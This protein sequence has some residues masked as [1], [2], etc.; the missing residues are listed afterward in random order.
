[1][2]KEVPQPNIDTAGQPQSLRDFWTQPAGPIPYP[3][4]SNPLEI[5]RT[6]PR[7]VTTPSLW[8]SV[9]STPRTQPYSELEKT[10]APS[11][12]VLRERLR[13]RGVVTLSNPEL[14]SL[15]LMTEQ[16]SESIM[17]RVNILLTEY[18]LQQLLNV[19]LGELSQQYGLGEAKA[20]QL[21]AMLE[22]SR[23]WTLQPEGERRTIRTAADAANLVRAEMEHL[24]HEE[25]RVL[26]L[27]TKNGVVANQRLYQGTVN[28]SVLR[29]AELFRLAV[30]RNCPGII[31]CHN[32]PSG[33]PEA[34]DADIEVTKGLVE[35][36][37]IL[38]VDLVDHII[39]GSNGR[40]TSLKEKMRW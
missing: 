7:N 9:S 29:S 33:S 28:S 3:L 39:I 35:A 25:L 40:F 10:P 11:T 4:P 12:K 21:Q 2:N 31:I 14:L 13:Q 37:K 17:G 16:G 20:A 26:T 5:R 38:E 19:E 32:H 18:S 22:M 34:S 30:T 1:M 24:D 8:G 23:R 6:S 36:G 27:D 15:V